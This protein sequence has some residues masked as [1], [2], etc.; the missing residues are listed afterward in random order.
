LAKDK[1]KKVKK[2]KPETP[3]EW[4]KK[5]KTEFCKFWLK[6]Q[7]C[8]NLTNGVGCGFAH[9]EE[10]LQRKKNLNKQYLTSI[11]KNFIDSPEKCTF[12]A[13]CIF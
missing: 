12:G 13:R 4:K 5:V 3:T 7:E 8:D 9:G 10:E 1:K 11:C 2:A 6:G